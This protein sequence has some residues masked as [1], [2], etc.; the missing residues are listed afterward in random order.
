VCNVPLKVI[1]RLTLLISQPKPNPK[2]PLFG[3]YYWG[4]AILQD[5]HPKWLPGLVETI[6]SC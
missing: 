2:Q 3:I 5:L 4:V 6:A 1:N